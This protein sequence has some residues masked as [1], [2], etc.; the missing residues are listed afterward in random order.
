MQA[1]MD[2]AIDDAEPALRGRLLFQQ[3]PVDDV[4][5]I[6]LRVVMLRA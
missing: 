3:R 1:W 4:H 2:I 6:L 5:A